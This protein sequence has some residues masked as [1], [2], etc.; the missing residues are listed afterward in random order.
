GT[1][2]QLLE[3]CARVQSRPLDRRRPLWEVYLI[4]GLAG[5]R[6]AIATK[7]HYAIMGGIGGIDAIDLEQVILDPTRQVEPRREA[8]WLP[9]PPPGRAALVLDAVSALARQPSAVADTVRLASRDVRATAGR[10][11]AVAGGMMS[12]AQALA[13]RATSSPLQVRTGDRRRFVCVRS[14]LA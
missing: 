2:E 11:L 4:E 9:P 12:A 6:V 8:V 1:D 5:E 13:T 3:F 10:V 14:D 7:T